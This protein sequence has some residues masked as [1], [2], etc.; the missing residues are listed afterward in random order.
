MQRFLQ[1][2]KEAASEFFQDD[3]MTLAAALALYTV[4]AL[5]PL[6]TVM[7]TVAGWIFGDAAAQGF[8]SQAEGLIGKSGGEAIRGIVENSQHPSEGALQA[9][10]GF[11]ILLV[12]ASAVFAQLQSSLNRIWNVVQKPGLGIMHMI[13]MRL[14]SMA[15]V[16]SLGFLLMVSLGVSTAV[17]ALGS[18]FQTLAPGTEFLLHI[19]NFLVAVGVTTVLFAGVF[20][21]MPD[22]KIRWSDVWVGALMTAVLFNVGQIGLGLYLGNSSTAAQYGAAGSF[23]VL[24]LWLYYSTVI[25]FYG[26]EWAQVRARILGSKLEPTPYA[27]RLVVEA[28]DA[29]DP[30][31]AAKA[32]Q[33]GKE[34]LKKANA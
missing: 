4:I 14:F 24:I 7:L 6:I 29:D 16:A 23:M 33:S 30:E 22:V 1:Y 15:V 25:L 17:A 31:A 13:K 9:V 32:T 12:S 28:R 26:A 18:Y 34:R 3:A 8:I 20:K 10:V 11:V 5:A 27:N 2:S 21:Y 19:L